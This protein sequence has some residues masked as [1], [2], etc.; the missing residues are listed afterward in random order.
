MKIK[1]QY[2]T[3]IVNDMDESVAFYEDV[4]GFKKGYSVNLG[5]NGRITL[6]KSAGDGAFVEL[7]ESG[8]YETGMYSIGTDV[9]DLDGVMAHL[10]E[11]GVK[12]ELGP[13]ETTVGRQ[14]FIKDPNGVNICLIEHKNMPLY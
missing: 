3:L 9:D 1:V 10:A 6:M 7:I 14:V 11:C 5:E 2:S 12:I 8:R 4:L 13:V